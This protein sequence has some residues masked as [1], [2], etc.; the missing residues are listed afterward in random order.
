MAIGE[1]R[2]L[3]VRFPEK[4]HSEELQGKEAVFHVKVNSITCEELPTLDDEFA[5]EVSDF[6]TFAEYR[7]DL[8]KRM[9]EAADE[10]STQAA[11]E[12]MLEG[13]VK[14][15]EID[16]P[17]PM[18][19]DKLDEMMDQMSWRMQ[20]QGF[21]L[22]KYQELTGQTEQQMREMYREEAT[23]ALKTEL[24]VEEIIKVEGIQTDE[25]QVEKMLE[26]Y[27]SA[28]GQSVEQLKSSL[29]EGQ[30]EYFS[31]RSRINK[32]YD[33]LWENAQVKDE[34]AKAVN[35]DEQA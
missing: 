20:Q 26:E 22:K 19:E 25:A 17:D 11:K 34:M 5:S 6:D 27:A 23:N 30:M 35:E 8:R 31:H 24:V 21:T 33:L 7:D 29:R 13:I 14:E 9:Q 1:E 16:I 10:Q 15:A 18:I 32:A 2:D 12:S 28:S 4:Y 3:T